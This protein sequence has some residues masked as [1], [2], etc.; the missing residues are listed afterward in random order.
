[1]SRL[2][3]PASPL[4]QTACWPCSRSNLAERNLNAA[5]DLQRR[6]RGKERDTIL[7]TSGLCL[8]VNTVPSGTCTMMERRTL[9][10]LRRARQRPLRCSRKLLERSRGTSPRRQTSSLMSKDGMTRLTWQ[11]W[12]PTL[13]RCAVS[14]RHA[15]DGFLT[16][17]TIFPWQIEMD[18]LLWGAAKLEEVGYG[19]KKLRI[20]VLPWPTSTRPSAFMKSPI[21]GLR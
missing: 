6:R 17:S 1:M 10:Q 13:G 9:P 12:R 2:V 11:R 19:I 4:Q 8:P 15:E 3:R 5:T 16:W 21:P 20:T 14:G 18:G 7:A